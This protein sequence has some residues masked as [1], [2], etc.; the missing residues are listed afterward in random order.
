MLFLS[1]RLKSQRL[2][3]I[4]GCCFSSRVK[5]REHSNASQQRTSQQACLPGGQQTREEVGHREQIDQRTNS[6][7]HA[8]PNRTAEN[9]DQQRFEE[10]MPQDSMSGGAKGLAH[11]NLASALAHR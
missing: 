7:G 6:V 5:R 2:D 10:E 11:T 1:S 3:G 4:D 8:Q 9:R